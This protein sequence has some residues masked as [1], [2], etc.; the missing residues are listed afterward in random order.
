[1]IDQ[2]W[3]EFLERFPPQIAIIPTP[4]INQL[5]IFT[6][7]LSTLFLTRLMIRRYRMRINRNRLPM[8]IGGWGTRGKSGTERKKA[9]L[10]EALGHNVVCKTTGCEAMIIHAKPGLDAIE[11]PIYRPGNKPTIW[12]QEKVVNLAAQLQAQVFLWECMALGSDYAGLMQHDWMN[13]SLSTI[14]NTFVDHEN[15]QGPAG[16]DVCRSMTSFIP[17]NSMLFTAEESMLPLIKLHARLRKTHVYPLLWMESD[18]IGQDVLDRF[19]YQVHPRNIGMVLKLAHH[20]NIDENWALREIAEHIVPDLGAFKCYKT[21]FRSRKLEFWSGM[22]ANDRTSCLS[23]WELAGFNDLDQNGTTWAVTIVNNRD[24]RIPRSHEFADILTHDTPANLH[25]LIGTNL[26]GMSG[27]LKEAM[28]RFAEQQTIIGEGI[29][30]QPN[31]QILKRAIHNLSR[32]LKRLRIDGISEERIIEKLKVMI[33]LQNIDFHSNLGTNLF[34]L[35]DPDILKVKKILQQ[36]NLTT[37]M[38][39][40]DEISAQVS[41]DLSDFKRVKAFKQY[42]EE[43]LG[44]EKIPDKKELNRNYRKLIINLFSERILIVRDPFA[45]GDQIIDFICRHTP[46]NYQIKMIGLQNI[47][48]TGLN[49]AYR[50]VSLAKVQSAICDLHSTEFATRVK[51]ANILAEHDDYG[52]M[53]APIAL[54]ELEKAHEDEKNS[55]PELRNVLGDAINRVKAIKFQKEQALTA[56]TQ[57]SF[58]MFIARILE[59]FFDLGESKRR[60]RMTK[61]IVKDLFNGNISHVKAAKL[62]HEIS[63]QQEGGWFLRKM[64]SWYRKEK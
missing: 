63:K 26:G 25:I 8:V 7:A 13:D 62:L 61:R 53:D 18:L 50:W 11:I 3:T 6:F 57:N 10:F 2:I 47:K 49:F 28:N 51:A 38:I 43:S 52:I 59:Q 30:N 1:M 29:Q 48:G 19:P 34:Q 14:S 64:K 46:V 54:A 31:D 20:W 22:S 60:Q 32:M 24:D 33:D 12:E 55:A 44:S 39:E 4:S 21:S 36:E 17:E 58:L 9:A 27:Y 45:T 37:S 35:T 5:V 40:L 16:I 42:L 15:V 41:H 23:N 56:T